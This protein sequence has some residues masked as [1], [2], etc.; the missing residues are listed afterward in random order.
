MSA[1][2]EYEQLRRFVADLVTSSGCSCCRDDEG[3]EQAQT[4][5]GKKLDVAP[6][7]DGS[8]WNWYKY[9][10]KGDIQ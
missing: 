1:E 10:T 3:W 7:E 6:Y 5:L 8:G 2:S 9:R 4:N